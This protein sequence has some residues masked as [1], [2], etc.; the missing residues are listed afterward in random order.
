MLAPSPRQPNP[1]TVAISQPM[2]FS[3]FVRLMGKPAVRP[4][5]GNLNPSTSKP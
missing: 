2:R 5:L 4:G 1:S 3:G